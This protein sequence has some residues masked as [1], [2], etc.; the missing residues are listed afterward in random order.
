MSKEREEIASQRSARG[1]QA[2][3]DGYSFEDRI[4]ELYRLLHYKVE[5][6]RLF[7]GRQVDL[8][9]TGRFGDM[10]VYRAIE[11]KVGQVKSD[12]IDSFIAKLRLVKRE[13]P[14]AMGTIVSAVSFTDAVAAQ[15]AQEGIQLTLYRDLAAQLVD[16][17]GYAQSLI[18][19]IESNERYPKTKYIEPT[20]GYEAVGASLPAFEIL[21][22]WLLDGEW[23]QLTLLGDVGT[24]K[25]F[26]SRMFA[27]RLAAKFLENPLS[28]PLPIR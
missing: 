12:H 25:S 6:G 19:E 15:A 9:L 11:C 26:I 3:D 23:N 5:H 2:Y 24:G 20:I 21:D 28:A 13:Y 8:F 7:G 18:R 27:L 4:D 1:R 22:E 16:G 10:R 17:Q 14:S